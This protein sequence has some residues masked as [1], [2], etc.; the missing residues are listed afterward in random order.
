MMRR[1]LSE[2]RVVRVVAPSV[3]LAV[4]EGSVPEVGGG[5]DL[6]EEGSALFL[7]LHQD[8]SLISMCVCVEGGGRG[9]DV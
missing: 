6:R 5:L 2:V 9:M 3:T 4:E 8:G 1:T 7:V